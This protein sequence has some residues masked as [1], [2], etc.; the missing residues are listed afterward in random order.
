MSNYPT[1]ESLDAAQEMLAALIDKASDLVT[2]AQD[3]LSD[4]Q[5]KHHVPLDPTVDDHGAEVAIH[6]ARSSLL[7]AR[8]V[9]DHIASA[10]DSLTRARSRLAT[11][12]QFMDHP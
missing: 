6:T 8:A 3:N 5:A 12:G 4:V 1:S 7:T 2:A 9:H 11:L 10:Y